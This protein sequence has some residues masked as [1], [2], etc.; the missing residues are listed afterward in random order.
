MKN[1]GNGVKHLAV[2]LIVRSGHHGAM[3]LIV[4]VQRFLPPIDLFRQG[5]QTAFNAGNI[6]P[7]CPLRPLKTRPRIPAP[8]AILKFGA[9]YHCLSRFFMV[10]G[11]VSRSLTLRT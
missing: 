11:L 6:R 5:N 7:G 9:Y 10:S 3:E 4:G 8:C 2:C 1:G